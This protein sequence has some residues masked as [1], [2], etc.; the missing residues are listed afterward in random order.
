METRSRSRLRTAAPQSGPRRRSLAATTRLLALS[1]LVATT[2]SAAPIDIVV[3]GT[4]ESTNVSSTINPFGLSNG[5]R[6]V[7]KSTY[8]DTTLFNGSEGVTAAVDPTVNP[9]TSFEVVIPHAAGAPNPLVFDHTDHTDI[10]FAPTAQIEFDGTDA[11]TDPGSFRNFEIHVDFNFAG[12]DMDFDTFMGAIQPETDLFNISQ[13]GNLAAVGDGAEHL[14]VVTNDVT[15]NAGGPHVFDA[16]TLEVLLSGT[17]GGG[18]GFGKTFDWSGSGGPLSNSPGQDI[19]LGIA[20]SGLTNVADTATVDLLVTENFTDFSAGD[21]TDISYE[22]ALPIVLAALGTNEADLSITFS[23]TTDDDDLV[24]NALISGFEDLLLEFLHDGDVF[25]TGEGNLD[26]AELLAIFGGPGIYDVT[27]RV[28]DLAGEM[29]SQP[30][31]IEVVASEPA[32][33]VLLTLGLCPAGLRRSRSRS[34]K[35]ASST[36]A[37]P[38]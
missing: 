7:M 9:G 28:T 3:I 30:F 29:A 33:L 27:A 19:L 23:A 21:S 6:F 10:G 8:D 14:Q 4:W 32:L 11:T 25:L 37:T 20:E 34:R 18:N 1:V 22:N 31:S 35:G 13:G 2:A 15:A 5:D 26:L 17:S 16:S 36:G 12:N 24:A 38:R